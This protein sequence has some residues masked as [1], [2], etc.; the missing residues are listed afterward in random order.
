MNLW[1]W[2]SRLDL[3][4]FGVVRFCVLLC[5]YT[6]LSLITL[7]YFDRFCLYVISIESK[8]M[9]LK[10][11]SNKGSLHAAQSTIHP[12]PLQT[13]SNRAPFHPV[14][15]G[16]PTPHPLPSSRDPKISPLPPWTLPNT[17]VPRDY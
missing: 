3:F 1:R 15:P 16:S 17:P 9:S 4:R 12:H 7:L 11:T 14:P 5:V 13:V 2:M 10:A 8:S 6:R